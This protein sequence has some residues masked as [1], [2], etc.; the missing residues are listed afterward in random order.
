M[1]GGNAVAAGM[2][3]EGLTLVV[4]VLLYLTHEDNM[5]ASVIVTDL[6]ANELGDRAM[7]KRHTSGPF[8]KFDSSK[9][10]GQRSGELP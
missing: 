10:I 1:A 8:F 9:L 3:D 7:E 5:V 4:L 2:K 6:A